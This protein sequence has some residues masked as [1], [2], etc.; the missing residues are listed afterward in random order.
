VSTITGT[1]VEAWLAEILSG[2][3]VAGARLLQVDYH[4][5]AEAEAALGWL[6]L[7]A[8]V[9]SIDPVSPALLCGP[10]L[11]RLQE[12]L[13]ERSI[14]VAHLKIFD[15]CASGWLKVSVTADSAPHPHGDLLADPELD[16]ELALNLRA[17]CDPEELSRIVTAALGDVPARIQIR[18]LRAFRPPPPKPEHR[19]REVVDS[20]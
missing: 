3:R 9:Q 8:V 10:L 17:L 13:L 14:F 2:G 20:V 16:H 19:F 1:G 7:N 15:Q 6:N 11:D 12:Q 4:R 18:H 5:Y